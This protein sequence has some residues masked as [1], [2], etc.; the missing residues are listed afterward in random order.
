MEASKESQL[1]DGIPPCTCSICWYLVQSRARITEFNNPSC[2]ASSSV[3][4]NNRMLNWTLGRRQSVSGGGEGGVSSA[5]E[6]LAASLA[7]AFFF[8]CN[9]EK[10][11][12]D[13]SDSFT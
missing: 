10:E 8:L 12:N 2:K 4:S 3:C 11:P 13:M 5:D 6:E 9:V 7:R 1:R